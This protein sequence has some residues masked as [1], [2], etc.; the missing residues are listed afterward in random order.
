MDSFS[1]GQVETVV[2]ALLG[3]PNP[4]LSSKRELRY[5][6]HGSLSVDLTK[7]TWFDHEAGEGGGL[8]DLVKH[9]TGG[10]GQDA[11]LWLQEHGVLLGNHR[12][13]AA[14]KT[15]VATY[16][17]QDQTGTL[18]FEVVRFAPKSFRPRRPDGD[19]GWVWS[20][21]GVH[22]VLY[23][24]PEL[25]AADLSVIVF[26]VEG[27]K[28]ADRLASLGL[29]S[30]TCAGGANKWRPEYTKCLKDRR[31]V[32]LPDCDE[33]GRKHARAVSVALRGV[34]RA[35]AILDLD[36]LTEKGDV[37]DWLDAGGTVERLLALGEVA[38]S[39]PP[40]PK[41]PRA[42]PI[43]P[44]PLVAPREPSA[45]YPM[46][47]L[48]PLRSL[49]EA[50]TR[51]TQAPAAIA[52]QSTL[53]A[54]ALATQAIADV[55]TL[56][57]RAPISLFFLTVAVS[58]ERK[59]TT[60]SI[61]TGPIK[62][63]QASRWAAYQIKQR[64]HADRVAAYDAERASVLRDSK[65]G[66]GDQS[67]DLD[68]LGDPPPAPLNPLMLHSD[69]TI[70]GLARHLE[71]GV[72]SI[73]IFSDEGG[74]ILGGHAM[75]RDNRLKTAAA[76]SK[77]WSGEPITRTRASEGAQHIEGT[78]V[79]VHLLIQ[80]R[81][82]EALFSDANLID[83][84]LIGRFLMVWPESQIGH[85]RLPE[86]GGPD[87][88]T[89]FAAEA[90]TDH[91]LALIE[92][93]VPVEADVRPELN[94]RALPLS[95]GARTHLISFYNRVETELGTGRRFAPVA[96]VAAKMAEQA[97]RLAGVLTLVETPDAEAVAPETMVNA[98]TLAD[99]Y[100]EEA[101]R[102]LDHPT[103]NPEYVD[104]ELLR[105]WL[106]RKWAEPLVSARCIAKGGP[107]RLRS[108]PYVRRL[109]EILVKAGWLIPLD[110][111]AT[112]RDEPVREAWRVI[113]P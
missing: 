21:E 47:A 3:A 100:L 27:E 36:G 54:A 44:M 71:H 22:R 91:L 59:S 26:L 7:G 95:A 25:I 72:R 35:V 8:I 19:G 84:G 79:S 99:W 61:V 11:S 40:D 2:R 63:L 17:Y 41:T 24:L 14:R 13:P 31:V 65:R 83:Q 29:I 60:D 68:T 15:Q 64:R 20:L 6:T 32:I 85:R 97:A 110:G 39:A 69:P 28:D 51:K 1:G 82:A 56:G 42:T 105:C 55:Q 58:G 89:D 108:T 53:A 12:P 46:D 62:Q 94:P 96:S 86:A 92:R 43:L 113:R 74:Q 111:K 101:L 67:A 9:H 112:I 109:I 57:G 70:E 23:R 33:P 48:G 93:F 30:T 4:T 77:L 80:P 38:L 16:A 34:A 98:I 73:G 88:A 66:S 81:I 50:A 87:P 52:A 37:S 78:R 103:T 102:I 107:N 104:A 5:G 10:T 76:L 75:N 49:A 18:L 90:V 106:D 45:P